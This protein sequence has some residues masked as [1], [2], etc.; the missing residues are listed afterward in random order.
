MS[1]E[2]DF[3]ISLLCFWNFG[4]TEFHRFTSPHWSQKHKKEKTCWKLKDNSGPLLGWK[5]YERLP[6]SEPSSPH[7]SYKLPWHNSI[8]IPLEF[9]L[10]LLILQQ[11][12][13]IVRFI[14][15]CVVMRHPHTGTVTE[16]WHRTWR[17][18]RK[19]TLWKTLI[20]D[21]IPGRAGGI[22]GII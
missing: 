3:K 2:N 18:Y 15:H 16:R 11:S 1:I 5:F 13:T 22:L 14:K 9:H 4:R 8:I 17:E 20:T 10:L 21:G 19:E 12:T 6:C 7:S